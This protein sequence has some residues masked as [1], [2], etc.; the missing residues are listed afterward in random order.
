MKANS[1]AARRVRRRQR[2]ERMR[3]KLAEW[4]MT[5]IWG[6]AGERPEQSVTIYQ[7]PSGAVRL[8]RR[9]NTVTLGLNVY[10]PGPRAQAESALTPQQAASLADALLYWVQRGELPERIALFGDLGNPNVC[11][12][13]LMICYDCRGDVKPEPGGTQEAQERAI[14]RRSDA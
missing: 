6:G 2:W 12:H 8:Y 4:L 9:V 3:W 7:S 11:P 10:E 14:L 13:G 5:G 1:R